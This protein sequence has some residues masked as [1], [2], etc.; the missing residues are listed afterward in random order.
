MSK[1]NFSIQDWKS[2][3]FYDLIKEDVEIEEGF[4]GKIKDKVS[5]GIDKLVLGL[6]KDEAEAVKKLKALMAKYKSDDKKYQEYSQMLSA[7]VHHDTHPAQN[8]RKQIIA[9]MKDMKGL[10]GSIDEVGSMKTKSTANPHAGKWRIVSADTNRP[11]TD[12]FYDSEKEAKAASEK[13]GQVKSSGIKIIQLPDTMKVYTKESSHIP[14]STATTSVQVTN[15]GH[16]GTPTIKGLR[17]DA[18]Q[19][20]LQMFPRIDQGEMDND[21]FIGL[22]DALAAY[23]AENAEELSNMDAMGIARHCQEASRAIKGRSGN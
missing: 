23:F 22:F 13:L 6:D 20:L 14:S 12:K 11:L 7:F 8:T 19:S 5:A 10:E 21:F 18:L 2:N 1:N 3:H 17:E 9:K 4:L 16:G 15:M